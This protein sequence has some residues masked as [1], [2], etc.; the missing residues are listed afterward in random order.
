MGDTPCGIF[1]QKQKHGP[2]PHSFFI[3]PYSMKGLAAAIL[4]KA[5][6]LPL[7]H[8]LHRRSG[9]GQGPYYNE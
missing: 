9:P 2:A 6:L 3:I 7:I 4:R 8:R 5:P 1:A